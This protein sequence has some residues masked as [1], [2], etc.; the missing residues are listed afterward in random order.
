ML[1]LLAALFM[2]LD[3]LGF[4]FYDSLPDLLV[5]ILR[6]TGRLAFPMF[7]YSLARGFSR[8][9]N[10]LAYFIR[11]AGFALIS[12]IAI[13][14]VFS[15]IN[16]QLEWTN[17]LITFTL[18]VVALTG[19]RLIRD[20]SLDVI[21]SLRPIPAAPNTVPVTPRFDVR[22]SLWGITLDARIG[23]IIGSFTIALSLFLSEWLKSDY[24]AYGILTV[25][26][27]YLATDRITEAHWEQRMFLYLVPLNLVFLVFRVVE[28]KTTVSWAMLQLFSILAIPVILANKREKRPPAWQ[29]YGFYIFYPAHIVLLCVVRYFLIGPF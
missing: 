25:L 24:G 29:K 18:A 21:A 11:L 12:E 14:L 13:R 8:T 7:A 26:A 20:S 5:M 1:K 27:F 10:L 16:L 2:V 3:H 4:Y 15:L 28:Q 9:H 19:F 23:I 17:V 6:L 22:I